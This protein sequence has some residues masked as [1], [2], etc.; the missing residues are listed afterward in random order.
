MRTRLFY[1]LAVTI[2]LGCLE[3]A[4]TER[5]NPLIIDEWDVPYAGRPRDPS[6]SGPDKVWFVGQRGHYLGMFTPSSG[7]FFKRELEDHPGPHNVIVGTDGIVWDTGNLAAYIGRYDPVADK[8]TRILMPEEAAHDPHTMAFSA[9]EKYI[10]F[11]VQRGNFVGRLSIDDLSI[12]LIEVTTS[13]ALPY[14]IRLAPDGTPW[15]ALFGTNKLAAINPSTL[16][17]TEYTLMHPDARPRRLE[18][19]RDSRIWYSDY[20][21]GTIG[22]YDPATKTNREWPLSTGRHS[23]PY[24]TAMDEQDRLW[25]V[26]TGV[27]PNIF[28]G[29]DTRSEELVSVTPIPSGAGS[30]RNMDYHAPS[31]S[32][33]FGTDAGTL[34]RARVPITKQ[35]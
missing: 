7:K 5:L 20:R 9:D 6:M 11:T 10:W 24:A 29:F 31:G 12:E 18:I 16:K 19:T 32:V 13:R 35:N 23:G 1:T 25:V 34:G 2:M 8:I 15:I 26:E 4:A 22:Q 3:V 21:R 30:V 33:W 14:G 17:L 28:V 27:T